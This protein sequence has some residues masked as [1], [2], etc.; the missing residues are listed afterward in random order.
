MADEHPETS[1]PGEFE[2]TFGTDIFVMLCDLNL[3][4]YLFC[5]FDFSGTAPSAPTGGRTG[6]KREW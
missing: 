1:F 2:G 4:M 5:N 6:L 3:V